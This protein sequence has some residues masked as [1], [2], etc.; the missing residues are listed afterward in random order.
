MDLCYSQNMLGENITNN[1]IEQGLQSAPR[2]SHLSVDALAPLYEG[3]ARSIKRGPLNAARIVILSAALTL[4]PVGL[5]QREI[6][7]VE[8]LKPCP[9]ITVST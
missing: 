4:L 7:R 2:A 3:S 5:T 8:S 9:V 6:Q 1:N